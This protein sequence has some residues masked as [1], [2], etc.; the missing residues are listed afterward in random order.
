MKTDK[1]RVSSLSP[2]ETRT[3]ICGNATISGTT[4][5]YYKMNPAL[6]V[7]N[8]ATGVLFILSLPYN[9]NV[10]ELTMRCVG[11]RV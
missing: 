1:I 6:D 11:A 10:S 4:E 9:V 7:E 3:D 2:G 5:D 8:I